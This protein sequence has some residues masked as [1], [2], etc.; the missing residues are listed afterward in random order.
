MWNHIIELF[1]QSWT[2]SGSF[3]HAWFLSSCIVHLQN[4][5]CELCKS[6]KCCHL[7]LYSIKKVTFVNIPTDLIRKVCNMWSCHIYGDGYRVFQYL[8]FPWKLNFFRWQ[9]ILSVVS[10]EVTGSC[11]LF[12]RKC[13]PDIQIWIII[14]CSSFIQVK[15]VFHG[16][17]I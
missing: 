12:L 17:G 16:K 9:Q 15:M 4:V 5:G 10:L 14:L 2:L 6:S 3:T 8:I 13:L 7:L 1:G 11:C